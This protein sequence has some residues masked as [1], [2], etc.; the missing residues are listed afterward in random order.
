MKKQIFCHFLLLITFITGTVLTA[1]SPQPK[2]TPHPT[3]GEK[4]IPKVQDKAV[5]ITFAC[6]DFEQW[7]YKRLAQSFHEIHPDITVQ[8]ILID[9]VLELDRET[10][11]WPEDATRRLV[12]AAD[13]IAMAVRLS[14]IEAG[15]IRDLRP[16]IEA[17][18][19]FRPDDFFPG[20]L[21]RYYWN[22]GIW[23]VPAASDLVL[24]FYNK[25]LFDKAGVPYPQIGWS[26]AD[27]LD[28][29]KRL[30]VRAGDEVIQYGFIDPGNTGA[31]AFIQGQAGKLEDTSTEPPLPRLDDPAVAEAIR[32]YIDLMP[33]HAEMLN[34]DED[35][36]LA[37]AEEMYRL[38]DEG[39]AA[40]WTD[41]SM[42]RKY[43]SEN[44]NLGIVPFPVGKAELNPILVSG[45]HMSAGTAHPQESWLWLEFLTRQ[46]LETW[47]QRM[48]ARRS[49]AEETGYWDGLDEETITAYRHA[50]EHAWTT[51]GWSEPTSKALIRAIFAILK[52]GKGVNEA[53]AEAQLE[54]LQEMATLARVT[55]Q[56]V[57][58]ATPQPAA[59]GATITFV[60]LPT[61]L[62]PY[63]ELAQAFN[64]AHPDITVEV[65]SG[66]GLRQMAES[67]DCFSWLFP[68]VAEERFRQYVLNLQPLLASDSDF[69]LDDFYP[70][71]LDAFR[72]QGD[73]WG[74]PADIRMKVI[75]YNRPLFEQ[76]RVEYP[77]LD[78]N[79][80]DLLEK[81]VALTHG[82]GEEKQYGFVPLY[83]PDDLLF[84]VEGRGAKL[85]DATSEPPQPRFNDPQV[86]EAVRWY[87]DLILKYGVRPAPAG[88]VSGLG[89]QGRYM[90]L[91]TTGRAAMWMD[92]GGSQLFFDLPPDIHV[93]PLPQGES[94]ISGSAAFCRGYFISRGTPYPQACWEWLKFLS[95]QLSPV[96]GLPP[97]RSLAESAQFRAQ[98]G[99]ETASVYLASL[100][101]IDNLGSPLYEQLPWLKRTLFWFY[102]AFDAILAG[103]DVGTALGEAQRKAEAYIRCLE[104]EEGFADEEVQRACAK[105]VGPDYQEFGQ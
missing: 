46:R 15:L 14:D 12:S 64:Q 86:V 68:H 8:T 20:T 66:A 27:L 30:T 73:L 5:T 59:K 76:A 62:A 54:A 18:K 71:A 49:V 94:G 37:Y 102:G 97:R 55:P 22:G 42:N 104:S 89:D 96:E 83:E 4:P 47:A 44:F 75:Y 32:W 98:V 26:F 51:W 50:L 31:L 56:P 60:S 70:Q 99:E 3:I 53:L 19:D 39:E 10:R 72:W 100:E 1:C 67:G 61:N 45:Y 91:V 74:L 57:A 28:K 17:D 95:E 69:S 34:Y 92:F 24:I 41:L 79:F 80:D 77:G 63:R 35:A 48:P 23:G 93:A 43:R 101:R 81:A 16:F 25:D 82:E 7:E 78:W 33:V 90:A 52:E 65:K 9:D 38:V 11:H 2:P 85:I 105:E 88:S 36:Y 6:Y 40:M 58:V 13:T 87:A 84:F 21:E 29:A 103:E